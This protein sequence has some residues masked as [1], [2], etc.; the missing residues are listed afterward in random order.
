MYHGVLPVTFNIVGG[1]SW[2]TNG[3]GSHQVGSSK[4][5]RIMRNGIPKL[6][7]FV[8]ID[9]TYVTFDWCRGF[10]AIGYKKN[11]RPRTI[12]VASISDKDNLTGRE[13]G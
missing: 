1:G 9:K 3:V 4:R 2:Q 7:S 5:L 13:F 12:F 6:N 8:T 10:V 11:M